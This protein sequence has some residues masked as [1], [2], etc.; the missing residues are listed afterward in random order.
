[1]KAVRWLAAAVLVLGC[2]R[3]PTGDPAAKLAFVRD[4]KTIRTVSLG[5]LTSK[6]PAETWSAHDPYY[7]RRKTYRALPIEAVLHEGFGVDPRTLAGSELVLRARDG[8]T[9][10]IAGARLLEGGAYLALADVDVPGWEPIGP[11]RA[12]PGP[13]YLVWR[14]DKQQTL[15]THPRPWQ[16]AEIGVARFEEV[17]P[18]TVP[19]GE[20][21]TSPA[22][23]GFAIFRRECVRCHAMNREGGRVGPD[24]NVPQSIVEYRPEAQIRAYVKNPLAFR[25]GAMPAH[26]HLDDGELDA[27]IA[28]FS[29]MKARKH[30]PGR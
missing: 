17:F 25:Y 14:G 20:A 10:P 24:L 1:M 23:H 3:A 29:A 18:H 22:M 12:N 2:G 15:E 4:G 16:L 13:V 9:V 8:Y 6:I 30:D 7:E 11:Q 28:Y 5:E 19:T 27:L 26:P 21:E